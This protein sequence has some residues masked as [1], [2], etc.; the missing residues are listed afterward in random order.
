M[1]HDETITIH[2]PDGKKTVVLK[3]RFDIPWFAYRDEPHI[4]GHIPDELYHVEFDGSEKY[5]KPLLVT[6]A[7]K[8]AIDASESDRSEPQP[9]ECWIRYDPVFERRGRL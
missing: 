3:A 7:Y 1:Y 5:D 9:D 8:D 4:M 6:R 2:G